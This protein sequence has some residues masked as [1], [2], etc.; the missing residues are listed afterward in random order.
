MKSRNILLYFTIFISFNAY[1]Q[2]IFK[3]N[4]N[5]EYSDT[6]NI[7]LLHKVCDNLEIKFSDVYIDK[8]H[9]INFKTDNTFFALQYIIKSTKDGNL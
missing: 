6:L 7:K 1:S 3:E 8:S 5:R 2:K 4:G 9:S